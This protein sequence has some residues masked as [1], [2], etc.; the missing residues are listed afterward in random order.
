MK[1]SA[2]RP[3]Y[4]V[5]H[6]L[7]PHLAEELLVLLW[8]KSPCH[9]DILQQVAAERGYRLANRS[10]DQLLASLGNL[11]IIGHRE[12]GEIYL[13]DFGRLIARIAKY[14]PHLVP[15]LI[16]FTYYTLYDE[17]TQLN[18]FS[19]AY[20]LV[21]DYL[22]S[23]GNALINSHHLV[24]LVQER[25]QQTFHDYKDYGISFSQNSVTGIVSWLEALNPPC[26]EQ[27]SSSS[28]SF[29][30]R[31]FCSSELL[32]LALEYIKTTFGNPMAAQLQ[33]SSEVR[34]AVSRLCLVEEESLDDLLESAS[35]AFG[36]ILR[37]TERG[38]WISLLGERSSFPLNLWFPS[39]THSSKGNQL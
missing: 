4:H 28:R 9:A 7:Q 19:W 6:D 5:R 12:H 31:P 16:H 13:S 11:R 1:T 15:E 33:L 34:N 2:N 10:S 8:D 3:F 37:Q 39:S 24:T 25:A 17:S 35:E 21:C 27:A 18:R 23:S 29:A 26:V 30:R 38:N 36:L 22:W 14:N 32:L 20:R